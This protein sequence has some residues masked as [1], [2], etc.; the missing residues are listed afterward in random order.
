[1]KRKSLIG[2]LAAAMVS[3]SVSGCGN[4]DLW[5]TVYTYD[6][7]IIQLQNGEVVEGRVEKWSD[8]EDGDQIQVTIDGKT[9]LEHSSNI[10]LIANYY[11]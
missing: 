8:Y 6:Y 4:K 10:D 3:I 7:A 2:L 5:D 1:M 9:Y 11:N